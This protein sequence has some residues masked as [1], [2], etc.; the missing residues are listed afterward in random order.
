M[1][2]GAFQHCWYSLGHSEAAVIITTAKVFFL[3]IKAHSSFK[4][5]SG[6]KLSPPT[7][8]RQA[9]NIKFEATGHL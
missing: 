2:S 3:V 4:E 5:I 6:S 7:G 9:K 1:C 8:Y